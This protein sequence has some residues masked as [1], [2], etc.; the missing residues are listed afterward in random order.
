M[1][2]RLEQWGARGRQACF[3]TAVPK[4][5]PP[6]PRAAVAITVVLEQ[7]PTN[8]GNRYLLVQRANDPDAGSWSLPGGKIDLGELTLDAAARELEE[9]TGLADPEVVRFY[10][11][12][13]STSDV[14]V[15][16]DD[17][18]YRFHYVLTHMLAFA[19]PAARDIA[20]AGDDAA[21]LGWFSLEE[22]EAQLQAKISSGMLQRLRRCEQLLA[23]RAIDSNSITG[24]SNMH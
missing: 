2:P 10:N 3:A 24:D 20:K 22:I 8:D 5:Y 6:F 18:A 23:S 16:D 12:S 4:D 1:V 17:G 14:I 15:K 21:D 13:Y 19:Q 7:S 11:S 9:E